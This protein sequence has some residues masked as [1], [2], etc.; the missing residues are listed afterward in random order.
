MTGLLML[1]LIK[2]FDTVQHD[3]LISKLE[4]YGY[5]GLVNHFFTSYLTN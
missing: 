4:H 1:D 3:I 2:A 5:S